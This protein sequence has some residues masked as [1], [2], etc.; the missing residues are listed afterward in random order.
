M[1]IPL[2]GLNDRISNRKPT[3][4]K[5]EDWCN[6][7]ASHK[8]QK[9]VCKLNNVQKASATETMINQTNSQIF[10]PST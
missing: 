10:Y 4:E 5:G 2:D 8:A 3:G 7:F 9:W 1:T 6:H